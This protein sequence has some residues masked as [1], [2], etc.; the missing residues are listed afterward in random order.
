MKTREMSIGPIYLMNSSVIL[1]LC[2]V[3]C[4]L[5]CI[6]SRLHESELS[7]E[8]LKPEAQQFSGC[9]TFA[10]QQDERSES[11]GRRL[12]M[13]LDILYLLRCQDLN[14]LVTQGSGTFPLWTNTII[15]FLPLIQISM[16]LS[17]PEGR[18]GR[19][20]LLLPWTWTVR[21]QR[22]RVRVSAA[23]WDLLPCSRTLQKCGERGTRPCQPLLSEII[24]C[25]LPYSP[26]SA[27]LK[28]LRCYLWSRPR[29]VPFVLQ[30][31]GRYLSLTY[32]IITNHN[33]STFLLLSS[34]SQ[35]V[36]WK[37]AERSGGVS[38][39]SQH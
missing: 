14:L 35:V 25:Q 15:R 7:S 17:D 23:V 5:L 28:R 38:L 20:F 39:P 27:K 29:A 2:L 24:R 36:E 37:T 33:T 1:G 34:I 8:E 31:H 32:P 21:G 9:V 10:L 12:F 16:I 18:G 3:A 13:K 4:A 30:V 19:L 6:S 22:S 26:A 11:P